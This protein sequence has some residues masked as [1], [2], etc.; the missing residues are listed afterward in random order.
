LHLTRTP[1]WAFGV[2]HKIP[3]FKIQHVVTMDTCDLFRL[4]P[5]I[6]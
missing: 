1:I 3:K 2:C 4:S 6:P 5:T